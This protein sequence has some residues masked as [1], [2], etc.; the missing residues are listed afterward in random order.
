MRDVWKFIVRVSVIVDNHVICQ[1]AR[2]VCTCIDDARAMLR[3]LE[4]R[5][6]SDFLSSIPSRRLL[7]S[8]LPYKLRKSVF[9][10]STKDYASVTLEDYAL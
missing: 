7:D 4:A 1:Q 8:K 3:F 9:D 10:M 5:A 6:M 2:P